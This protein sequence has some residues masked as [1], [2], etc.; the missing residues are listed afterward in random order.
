MP[1]VVTPPSAAPGP[2][3]PGD[4]GPSYEVASSPYLGS[5]LYVNTGLTVK[6]TAGSVLRMNVLVGGAAGTINDCTATSLATTGN[7]VAVIPATV[8]NYELTFPCFSGIT[9][10]PG[11][12]QVVSI[13]YA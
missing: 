13:S 9:I 12:G 2:S 3:Q 1:G 4:A 10:M 6:T 5:A 7:E 11:V 8:G